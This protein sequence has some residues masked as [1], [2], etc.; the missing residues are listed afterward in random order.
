MGVFAVGVTCSS[1]SSIPVLDIVKFCGR[2]FASDM[3]GYWWLSACKQYFH[4]LGLVAFPKE[5]SNARELRHQDDYFLIFRL[6]LSTKVLS[7]S[8]KV[9]LVV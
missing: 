7:L 5:K 8:F 1:L 3:S 6:H 2:L 4:L 9:S